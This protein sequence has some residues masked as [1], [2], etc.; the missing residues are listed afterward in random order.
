MIIS[1]NKK[2][3]NSIKEVI[4]AY[5]E[6]SSD[7][8]ALITAP[9]KYGNILIANFELNYELLPTPSTAQAS[10]LVYVN[11]VKEAYQLL[12]SEQKATLESKYNVVVALETAIKAL[13]PETVATLNVTN[14]YDGKF[15][16]TGATS[17]SGAVAGKVSK[18]NSMTIV[19]NIAVDGINKLTLGVTTADKGSTT[20]NV[21]YSSNGETWTLIEAVKSSSNSGENTKTLTPNISGACFIKIEVTC[22]KEASNSKDASL[23][24]LIVNA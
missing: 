5:N 14:F 19:S 1:A 2:D 12:T 10:D 16:V 11:A 4:A 17:S 6:L 20:F 24:K 13:G 8:K 18:A 3:L 9:K 21:Y 22:T 23:T 15:E 7:E